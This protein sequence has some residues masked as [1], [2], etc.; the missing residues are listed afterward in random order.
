[1]DRVLDPYG[2]TAS[3]FMTLNHVM[4]HPEISRSDLARELQVTPQAVGGLSARLGDEGLLHRRTAQRGLPIALTLSPAG[5]QV[6]AHAAPAIVILALDLLLRCVK[7]EGVARLD[8]AF[9]HVLTR[10]NHEPDPDPPG[11]SRGGGGR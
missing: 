1:M 7:P 5:R 3:Q 11:G 4:S 6:L 2:L 9:R 8:G 10:L